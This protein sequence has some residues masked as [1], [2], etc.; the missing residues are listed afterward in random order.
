[1]MT[2]H[3]VHFTSAMLPWRHGSAFGK[4]DISET[5]FLPVSSCQL[6]RFQVPS[7]KRKN[8]TPHETNVT[9][10]IS[11]IWILLKWPEMGGF[12]SGVGWT[13]IIFDVF[14]FRSSRRPEVFFWGIQDSS[15]NSEPSCN[16]MSHWWYEA[17]TFLNNFFQLQWGCLILL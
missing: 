15:R 12:F 2:L 16:P 10:M 8:T 4:A 6:N 5:K 11:G 7:P 14:S 17:Q 13:A 1:M 9:Q 3:A